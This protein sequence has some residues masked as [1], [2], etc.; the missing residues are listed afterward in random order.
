MPKGL[1]RVDRRQ[2][3]HGSSTTTS[4]QDLTSHTL[5]DR[6][7]RLRVIT[8][9]R[10]TTGILRRHDLASLL[11]SVEINGTRFDFGS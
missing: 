10:I 7:P 5:I 6:D 8:E 1:P 2:W 4:A 9:I 3:F 11:R